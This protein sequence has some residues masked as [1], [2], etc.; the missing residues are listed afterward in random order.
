[1]S[2]CSLCGKEATVPINICAVQYYLC[3]LCDRKMYYHYVD[4]VIKKIKHP[5]NS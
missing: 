5:N 1:M 2:K 4:K 3:E